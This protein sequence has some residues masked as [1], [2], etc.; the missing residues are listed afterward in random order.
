MKNK[1]WL[2]QLPL[3]FLF[4][5][6]FYITEAG[7]QG[8]LDSPTL[9]AQFFRPLRMI[10]G[11]FTNA[12]FRTRGPIE[13]KNKIVIVEVENDSIA[14]F[15]R[16]PWHRD[17]SAYL[18]QSAFQAGAKAVGLDITFSEAD[19]RVAPELAKVLEQ[20][21]LGG[22]IQQFE[23]DR[24]LQEVIA[25]NQDRVALGWIVE[26]PCQ[27]KFE[28]P[29]LCPVT[30]P[31]EIE[32]LPPGFE[33]FAYTHF[34]NHFF[35]QAK[36]PLISAPAIIA[37]L[38]DYNQVAKHSGYFNTWPDDDGYIRYTNLVVT[39]NGKAYPSL[40]LEMAR[41][42]LGEELKVSLKPDGKIEQIAFAKSGRSIP[43]SPLGAM[44]INFRGGASTFQYVRANQLMHDSGEITI[45]TQ[46]RKIA[47]VSKT[48]LLKDAYVFV[49]LNA[50]GVNDMRSFPFESFVPGVEGH[51]NILDNILSGDMMKGSSKTS[52]VILFLL[53]TLGAVAFA[54]AAERLESIPALL[55]FVVT[56]AGLSF[57]DLKILFTRQ[58]LNWNTGFLYLEISSIFVITL[59]IK[60][61][62]EEKNKKFIKG[63]FAKY[64]S[65]AI[66]D[67]ILKDPTKLTVGGEKRELTI[68][69]SDIR[70]FTSFSE[71]MDAKKLATFL[72]SYLGVMT[73]IVFECEGTL[74]KY[75]GDAVMAFWGAPLDQ[76]KHAANA[77][78]AAVRMQKALAEHKDRFKQEFGVDV[79]IGIGLNSG[80]VNVGNMG[81]EKI[82]E[83][84]VIGDHVNL[85]SRLEGLTKEYRSGVVTSRFTLDLVKAAGEPLPAHRVLDFVKVKGKKQ[86]V[87]L[88]Q[89]LEKDLPQEALDAFEKGRQEYLQKNWDQ[90]I[91]L[92]A[93][94]NEHVK[95]VTG[96]EDGPSLLYVERCQEFKLRPPNADWDGSWEMHTK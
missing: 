94:S 86:A 17:V 65:P 91:A 37:N 33:K 72:N 82:F 41:I 12:K 26:G 56:L 78:K 88:I 46:D 6:A 27:P 89:V 61:V 22:L 70:G 32:Q 35:N 71:K 43:V 4:T 76:P 13:P 66:I 53:M 83:Y 3:V 60:Y 24:V 79:N 5:F 73:D 50:T 20:N 16:W 1:I 63:A 87:E 29:E 23:T 69:F 40:A 84:T 59:A 28:T 19:V 9:R 44:E 67:S 18:I 25:L 36:T 85:A 10:T 93:Q 55:L 77:L 2:W 81:S 52:R 96:Q 30:D 54:I 49:G 42:G 47:S 45:E 31:K 38:P 95:K 11:W 48:D 34:E 7:I 64:V 15:G 92:F 75:I 58:Q 80:P 39:A 90:A 51:A 68:L 8:D 57:V 14:E 21:K 62:L 74:D